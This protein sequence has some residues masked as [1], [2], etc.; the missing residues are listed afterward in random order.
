MFSETRPK[1]MAKALR[2]GSVP[3]WNGRSIEVRWV[4]HSEWHA[5]FGAFIL[6]P[7]HF[8]SI[9]PGSSIVTVGLN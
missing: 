4:N 8:A 1:R 9:L 6:E 5:H 2:L 3:F 7:Y